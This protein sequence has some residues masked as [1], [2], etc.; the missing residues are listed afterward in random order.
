MAA[1]EKLPF[2]FAFLSMLYCF[3]W[4]WMHPY[5]DFMSAELDVYVGNLLFILLH[6]L[7]VVPML[8]NRYDFPA[9]GLEMLIAGGAVTI[10]AANAAKYWFRT[11]YG[12]EAVWFSF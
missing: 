9:Y 12:A 10:V 2:G 4:F 3:C 5:Y 6:A 7:I 8:L 11:A 1:R